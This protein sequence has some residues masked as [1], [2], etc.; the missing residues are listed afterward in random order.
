MGFL[1]LV[2]EDVLGDSLHVEY[3]FMF[4]ES[5]QAQMYLH[6]LCSLH[7]MFLLI[8]PQC[9]STGPVTST[10]EGAASADS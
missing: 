2:H 3:F 5:S 1:Y 9:Q 4:H 7:C 8:I 6:V 10:E